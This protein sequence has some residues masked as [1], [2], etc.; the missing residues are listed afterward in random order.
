MTEWLHFHFSL[1]CTGE[2]NGNP[3][4]CSCLESPR[5]GG[6][7]W[8]AVYRVAQSRTRLKWLSS[9]NKWGTLQRF[10]IWVKGGGPLTWARYSE[11]LTQAGVMMIE[12]SK[13][14]PFLYLFETASPPPLGEC[15]LPGPLCKLRALCFLEAKGWH[16][17]NEPMGHS[18][19]E[20]CPWSRMR[21]WERTGQGL[22]DGKLGERNLA[23]VSWLHF[24]VWFLLQRPP[25]GPR[26]CGLGVGFFSLSFILWVSS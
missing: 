26:S 21:R 11:T 22:G 17:I 3:L 12:G 18:L 24:T 13:Q 6:A 14:Q 16:E 20:L 5:D 7:W 10:K 23:A 1:P 9:S 8:A 2:G 19:L 25:E 4:Q 15:L